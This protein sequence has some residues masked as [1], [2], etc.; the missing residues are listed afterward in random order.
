M[1]MD[2][3]AVLTIF[4]YLTCFTAR[5]GTLIITFFSNTGGTFWNYV[6]VI[7]ITFSMLPFL[8]ILYL[9]FELRVVYLKLES[10]SFEEFS[11]WLRRNYLC[12]NLIIL[13]FAIINIIDDY[14]YLKR[15]HED[16]RD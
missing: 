15:L 10:N 5:M 14:F 4:L 8:A 12:R 9:T 7:D 11:K 3:P 16:K 6:L 13:G 2:K 1:K